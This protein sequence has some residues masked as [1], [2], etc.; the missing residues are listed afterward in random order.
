MAEPIPLLEGPQR[1]GVVRVGLKRLACGMSLVLKV[2]VPARPGPVPTPPASS[3]ARPNKAGGHRRRT[4]AA[5]RAAR[6]SGVRPTPL[7]VAASQIR[8]LLSRPPEAMSVLSGE[9]ATASTRSVCP[10]KCRTTLAGA[11]VPEDHVV[12]RLLGGEDE[13][14]VVQEQDGVIEVAGLAKLRP[15]GPGASAGH[16]PSGHAPVD[17]DGPGGAAVG[18]ERGAAGQRRAARAGPHQAAVGQVPESGVV[19]VD[20]QGEPAVGRAGDGPHVGVVA[21]EQAE[22][23]R[24][25]RRPT[26]APPR[27]RR[28]SAGRT[29]RA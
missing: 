22:R 3:P 18:G 12:L 17:G 9:T 8:T 4:G 6:G 2:P 26:S 23:R 28:R 13:G 20:G 10:R 15:G 11:G 7:P 19:A 5:D 24:R 14:G 21:A 1:F 27:R 16:L 29:G 25:W